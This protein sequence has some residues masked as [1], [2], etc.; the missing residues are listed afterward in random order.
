MKKIYKIFEV[1]I[2]TIIFVV[3]FTLIWSVLPVKNGPRLFVVLSGSMEPAIHTGSVVVI[4]PESQ[5][6]IGDVV[7][8][9]KDTAKNIPT[10]HRIISSRAEEGVMIFKTKGDANNSP[11]TTEI[12]QSDIHGKVFFNISYLGYVIDFVRKPIGMV[13]V[14]IL[15]AIFIVYDEVKKILNEIK[16]MKKEKDNVANNAKEND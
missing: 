15:P 14:I 11:D 5:Y 10:T 16:K 1:V 12:R 7:T 6:K 4:K 3:A 9:G 2:Y 8:F 13:L